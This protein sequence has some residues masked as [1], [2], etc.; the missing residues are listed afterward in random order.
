M[1]GVLDIR[2]FYFSDSFAFVMKKAP[3]NLP[4]LFLII[5]YL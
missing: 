5:R 1:D 2:G 3:R 4:H